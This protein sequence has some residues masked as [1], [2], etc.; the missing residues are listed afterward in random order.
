MKIAWK[1]GGSHN[2]PVV[3]AEKMA[4]S[5][6]QVLEAVQGRNS[7]RP[8]SPCRS[9]GPSSD[10]WICEY[11]RALKLQTGC[12]YRTDEDLESYPRKS[13]F[14]LKMNYNR[15]DVIPGLPSV[16]ATAKAGCRLCKMI[17][18]MRLKNLQTESYN[19][20]SECN[21]ECITF[22]WDYTPPAVAN[23]YLTIQLI[24]PS[25]ERPRKPWKLYL[26]PFC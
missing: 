2:T 15:T 19:V 25:G 1:T 21:I 14:K 11:C 6:S 23:C 4:A 22:Q 18:N 7:S 20:H 17:L 24:R 5:S 13:K 8:C 26:S 12:I 9:P 10:V 16:T 3:P